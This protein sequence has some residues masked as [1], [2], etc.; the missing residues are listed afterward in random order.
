MTTPGIFKIP[1][2]NGLYISV[3]QNYEPYDR[4]V[5]V[6]IVDENDAWLYNLAMI[7]QGH[8]FDQ[9]GNVEWLGKI[10]NVWVNTCEHE[11][12]DYTEFFEIDLSATL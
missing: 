10:F 8:Q 1:I 6:G 7:R 12:E 11:P 2:G 3:E 5:F 9:D 4:E